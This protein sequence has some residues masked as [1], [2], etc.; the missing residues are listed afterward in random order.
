MKTLKI[1]QL[2]LFAIFCTVSQFSIGQ[3]STTQNK[4]GLI[5]EWNFESTNPFHDLD[6]INP[7]L[8]VIGDPL[9][10]LKNK[11]MCCFLPYGVYRAEASVGGTKPHYHYADSVD[12]EHGDEIWAGVRILKFKEHYTGVNKN[13]SIFQIG[14]VQNPVTYPGVTSAGHFQLQLN[15]ETDQWKWREFKT[16]YNPNNVKEDIS[17][18]NY[19]KWEKFVFHCKFRSN[20]TGLMEIW[21]N[22]V[23]IYSV[24]RLNGIPH[25]RT[26]I[27][28][29]VY[30]GAG[31]TVH[32]PIRCYFDDIKIGGANSSYKEVMP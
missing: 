10:S 4:S 3:K 8:T 31:N 9:D 18:V 15:T 29:G 7:N 1:N 14:P 24:N 2:L 16:Q 28:W 12:I 22:G 19:G 25:D 21:Q 30:I 23:K 27:K 32:E 5:F 20:N 13:L 26:R 17:P 11:V 6:E